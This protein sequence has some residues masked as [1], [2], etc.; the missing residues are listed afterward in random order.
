MEKA[1]LLSNGC[2][3]IY[4]VA[5]HANNMISVVMFWE[6]AVSLSRFCLSVPFLKSGNGGF[7]A[8]YNHISHSRQMTK[9]TKILRS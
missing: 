4:Q 8:R 7:Y 3:T 5:L 2:V 6:D 9:A 1:R